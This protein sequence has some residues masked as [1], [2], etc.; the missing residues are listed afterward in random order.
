MEPENNSSDDFRRRTPQRAIHAT[1]DMIQPLQDDV[2]LE[3]ESF[4]MQAQVDFDDCVKAVSEEYTRLRWEAWEPGYQGFGRRPSQARIKAAK[5]RQAQIGREVQLEAPVRLAV[6]MCQATT[7]DPPTL[8]YV[9]AARG[10]HLVDAMLR[11]I[12]DMINSYGTPKP[13]SREELDSEAAKLLGSLAKDVWQSHQLSVLTE[14][15]KA[16]KAWA[17]RYNNKIESPQLLVDPRP[18][19]DAW[20]KAVANGEMTPQEVAERWLRGEQ[21]MATS[22][23]P[24]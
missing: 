18:R 6:R 2:M 16:M 12:L 3:W 13:M 23:D 11:G 14:R 21:P 24:A 8:T 1:E 5:A 19:P 22:D 20:I 7:A 9:Q 10:W 15:D 4:F 17:E